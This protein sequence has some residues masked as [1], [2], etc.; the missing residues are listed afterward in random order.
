[1][2]WFYMPPEIIDYLLKKFKGQK[3]TL[4]TTYTP[5]H[6]FDMYSLGMIL[7]EICVGFPL[8]ID[9][10]CIVNHFNEKLPIL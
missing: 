5:S 10:K 3:A 4:D 6:A 2:Q 8:W 9:K 7:L 1:M